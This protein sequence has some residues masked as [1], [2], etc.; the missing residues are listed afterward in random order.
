[1]RFRLTVLVSI[2]GVAAGFALAD[3]ISDR[4]KLA[5]TWQPK[6]GERS[7]YGTWTFVDRD[8]SIRITEEANGQ[9][10]AEFECNT[11]GRECE[12]KES[13][14]STKVSL[15]YN[16]PKLVEMHT[17]GSEVVKRRFQVT[18]GDVLELEVIPIAPAGKPELIHMDRLRSEADRKAQ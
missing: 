10:I 16:G 15:W 11:M 18:D 12:V 9:K 17:R 1:M 5:G 8:G 6:A 13:G 4:A 3:E 2:L 14:H 7:D